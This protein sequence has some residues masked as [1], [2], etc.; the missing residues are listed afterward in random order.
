M[1]ETERRRAENRLRMPKVTAW[2]D[3]MRAAFGDDVRVTYASEG[4]FVVGKPMA[5]LP[6]F[7]TV[8]ELN[9]KWRE[10]RA[11]KYKLGV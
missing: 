1:T 11:A 3:E 4:G 7:E 6:Q 2:V 9:K 10:Q 8:A 5:A